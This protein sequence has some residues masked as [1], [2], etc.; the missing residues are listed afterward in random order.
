MYQLHTTH[1]F[2]FS[3]ILVAARNK[4]GSVSL[5]IN[6]WY[7][8]YRLLRHGV[9]LITSVKALSQVKEN[10]VYPMHKADLHTRR[11]LGVCGVRPS[12]NQ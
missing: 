5:N 1:T 10:S 12:I 9:L 6:D 4:K 3:H 11:S 8:L 2:I 7:D